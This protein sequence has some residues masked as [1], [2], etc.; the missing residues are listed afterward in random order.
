METMAPK[1]LGFPM[2]LQV[3]PTLML[4]DNIKPLLAMGGADDSLGDT[5]FKTPSLCPFFLC[6]FPSLY[7][8][9]L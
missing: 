1:E 3:L 6:S 2:A 8:W 7:S 5:F 9:S 4:N